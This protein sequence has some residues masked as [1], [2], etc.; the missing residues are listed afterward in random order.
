MTLRELLIGVAVVAL[1]LAALALALAIR[2]IVRRAGMG[3]P[4]VWGGLVVRGI[5]IAGLA[6]VGVASLRGLPQPEMENQPAP[7]AEGAT[8]AFL[9]APR[10][11]D[12]RTV[13]DV[14]ARDGAIRWTR[15]LDDTITKLLYPAPG[16]ILAQTAL[17][18]ALGGALVTS[19]SREPMR[20]AMW[21]A[22]GQRCGVIAT[23]DTPAPKLLTDLVTVRQA[24]MAEIEISILARGCLGRPCPDLET[25]GQRAAALEV[26]R[27]AK[28]R[29]IT[30][31]FT[32][33]QARERLHQLY[34]VPKTK[35]DCVLQRVCDIDTLLIRPARRKQWTRPAARRCGIAQ[36]TGQRGFLENDVEP[37]CA[38]ACQRLSIR[39]EYWT[40]RQLLMP[41]T[42]AAYLGSIPS[43]RA[44][45]RPGGA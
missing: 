29:A 43:T 16:V 8:V 27:N 39:H 18:L 22:L 14:S 37:V 2:A 33:A 13:V 7:A 32:T 41:A 40:G 23:R 34:P 35:L 45:A 30:W 42:A 1:A 9:Q 24:E 5:L 20:A 10:N 3:Q 6:A 44:P 31:R 38:A 19:L 15:K 21:Q 12:A 17:P 36:N 4:R 28:Q 26:A 11:G 25:L